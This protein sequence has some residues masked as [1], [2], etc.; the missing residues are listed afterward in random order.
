LQDVRNGRFLLLYVD[1]KQRCMHR[2]TPHTDR[3]EPGTSVQ[4]GNGLTLISD[5]YISI[6]REAASPHGSR[7]L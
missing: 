7:F 5:V 4:G 2:E 6:R 3:N 1:K